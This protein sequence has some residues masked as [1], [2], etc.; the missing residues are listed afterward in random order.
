MKLKNLLKAFVAVAS[1]VGLANCG[2]GG[3]GGGGGTTIIY[4]PFKNVFGDACAGVYTPTP[5][6]TFNRDGSRVQASQSSD[7]NLFGGK[8]D[9]LYRVEFDG[10]GYGEVWEII[11]GKWYYVE[12]RHV[13]TFA[14]WKGGNFIGVGTTGLFWENIAFGDY[15]L[16]SKGVLYSANTSES[17]FFEAINNKT[18]GLVANTDIIASNEDINLQLTEKAA[19][20]LVDNY[21]F[22]PAKAQAI[23]S[24]L[25]RFAVGLNN[26]GYSTPDEIKETF[27]STF[28]V[29]YGSAVAAVSELIKGNPDG[30]RDLNS[31]MANALGIQPHDAKRFIQDSYEQ[32]LSDF[33]YTGSMNW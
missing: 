25:N 33:G 19:T 22:E 2:G 7:Y 31:R 28:G 32:A 11:N 18:A 20:K 6:C 27:Q 9:D 23:A 4:Y 14:G 1:V 21:G 16:D 8:S 5:G 12:T 26:R 24:Q 15:Y 13:S 10:S 29:D 17:N 30:M 3:G